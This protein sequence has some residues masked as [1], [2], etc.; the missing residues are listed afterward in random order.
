[1]TKEEFIS[2][3]TDAERRIKRFQIVPWGIFF[4]VYSAMFLALPSLLVL[5]CVA[6][7]KHYPPHARAIILW[8]IAACGLLTGII[9]FQIWNARR[10]TVDTLTELDLKCP[11]CHKFVNLRST[12]KSGLCWNCGARIF[13]QTDAPPGLN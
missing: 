5:L 13:D 2:R 11:S 6:V 10:R 1:M 4:A 7:F 12:A 9:Q 3:K 8:E